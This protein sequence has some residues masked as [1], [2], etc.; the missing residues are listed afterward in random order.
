MFKLYSK[1][2]KRDWFLVGL[3]LGFTIL[4]VYCTMTMTDYVSNIIR[5]ITYLNYHNNPAQL[6]DELSALI[7]SL[8]GFATI[9]ENGLDWLIDVLSPMGLATSDIEMLFDIAISSTGDIWLNAGM[10]VLAAFGIAAAQMVIS[11]LSSRVAA[12]QATR[13]RRELS[14]KVAS[15]SLAEINSFSTASLIT[16][17]TNDVSQVQMANIMVIR[18]VLAAPITVIWALCKIQAAS[19]QL[20]VVTGLFIFALI[21]SIG[22]VMVLVIPR[23]KSMQKLIDKL[24]LV[25][26]E[27]LTGIRVVRAYNSEGYQIEKSEAANEE[28]TK[29]NLFTSEMISILSPTMAV[30]MSGLSLAIYWVG[31]S[32]IQAGSTDY[33]TVTSFMMLGS[34]VIMSFVMLL[35][36]FVL[37]PRASVSAKRINEVLMTQ[38]SIN[39]PEHPRNPKR[40]GKLVFDHV[41]FRYPDAAECVLEDISFTADKGQTVA[42]I[43]PTGSGK[44]SL[45]NLLLRLYDVT[46]G[47]VLVDGV[48]VKDMDSSELRKRFGYVPQ[49]GVLFSGSV[50]KNIALGVPGLSQEKTKRAAK[51]AKA[52][53]FI[54]QMDGGYEARISQGGK[55]VSGGQRQRLCIA[56]AVAIEPEFYIFDDSFSALDYKT[57][58][59]VRENLAKEEK[60]A[61]K[62]IVAQRIGTIMD[63]DTIVVLNE[64]KQVGMGT[65]RELLENCPLYRDIALS[66]LSKE[67]LGL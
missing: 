39:E 47:E 54:N 46:E 51:I 67:E 61:T 37:W 40:E 58:R 1:F 12:D 10:M 53:E 27:N 63:A 18:M 2:T 26:R 9:A 20:T 24:N 59:E 14:E 31:A 29:A 5:S 3:I 66:Q 22:I 13:I 64:G 11:V 38:S 60:D 15:F 25:V 48:N 33:A 52:D 17:S 19:W 49:K 4:Q 6:G 16:R 44:S 65:H 30:I 21:L 42:F 32:L 62:F 23:F 35:M 57:D 56:R 43:G 55:N 34:Q 28:L 7:T 36:M 45:V 41:S 8:G 50:N